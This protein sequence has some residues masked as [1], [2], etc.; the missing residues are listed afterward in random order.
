MWDLD[1]G[2]N[3]KDLPIMEVAIAGRATHL[4]TGDERHFGPLFGKTV[5]AVKV[6]SPKML[7]DDC[8]RRG[9]L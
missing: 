8:A 7:A 9:W 1:V 5:H 2:L 4:L 3:E 6:I